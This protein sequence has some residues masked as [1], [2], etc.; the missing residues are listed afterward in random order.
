MNIRLGL[1]GLALAIGTLASVPAFAQQY[2]PPGAYPVVPPG[3][4]VAAA[5]GATVIAPQARPGRW[6]FDRNVVART[7]MRM[8]QIDQQ[9][10]AGISAG[11]VQPQ[12]LEVLQQQRARA[13]FVL[14][15]VT[16]D[17]MVAPAERQRLATLLDH[18]DQLDEQY[19]VRGYGRRA[20]R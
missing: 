8:D 12:A 19:R 10:R 11:R 4:A 18:M 17:G 6:G 7:R 9:L 5:P 14:S 13:E 15:R 1:S 16:R 2:Y 3:T 20:W